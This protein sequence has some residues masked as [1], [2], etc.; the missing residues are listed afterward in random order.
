MSITTASSWPFPVP[1][2]NATTS[3]STYKQTIS[4][5]FI[6]KDQLDRRMLRLTGTPNGS[7]F[8][9]THVLA[10]LCAKC[11]A[12]SSFI[13]LKSFMS[14]RKT[15]AIQILV[16]SAFSMMASI[17]FRGDVLTPTRTTL[18]ISD[19]PASRIAFTFSQQARVLSVMLPSMSLPVL[20]AGSWPLTQ[21]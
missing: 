17:D 16:S 10:G 3:I 2:C 8:T 7:S 4:I 11:L 15:Y 14:V 1:H 9:E 6:Q 20:S 5:S 19:P 12:Y 13:S 21:I 18:L